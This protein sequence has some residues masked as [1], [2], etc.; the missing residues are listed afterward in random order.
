MALKTFWRTGS[1]GSL[2][3]VF[4][5]CTLALADPK[6]A[7]EPMGP[8]GDSLGSSISPN[9]EHIAVLANQGSHLAVFYDGVA[10]PKIEALQMGTASNVPY[11][12]PTYYS[13]QVPI[14]FSDDGAHWAYM[15]R[16]G[17][18][19]I[20]MLDGK[21]L[22]RAPLRSNEAD[23]IPLTFSSKGR[24]L[25]Y[26]DVDATGAYQVVVDGK[27]GPATHLLPSIA[28]SPDGQHYAYVGA[29][30]NSGVGVWS[31]VDG[32]QVNYF[33]DHLQ[34][35]GR[36][37][38]V[39]LLP[40]PGGIGLV[41]DGKPEI[42][43]NRLD[44][45]WM[46]PD[47]ALIAIV[48]TPNP[49]T[50]SVLTINGKTIDGTQ[51]LIIE[52]VYFSPDGKRWA[53]LCDKKTGSKFMMVDGQKG[54]DYSNIM[55]S[56]PPVDNV[57]H[58]RYQMDD[59]NGNDFSPF[60]LPVPGFTADS[61]K[62]VYAALA[63]GRVFMIVDGTESSGFQNNTGFSPV[64]STVGNHI[65]AVGTAPNN[66]QHLIID[67]AEVSSIPSATMGTGTALRQLT[68]S[69]GAKH[70]AF[71]Q[72]QTL[73]L[74]SVAQPGFLQNN[75]LF[76]PDD[77]HLAYEAS[78][79][80]RPTLVV[81]GKVISDKPG[82]VSRIFFSPDSQHVCWYSTG[83]WAALGTK[84]DMQLYVDGKPATHFRLPL[85]GI[86]LRCSFGPDDT[87]TFM[88]L[89]DG[90]IRRFHVTPDT[91]LAAVLASAPVAKAN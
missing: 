47:G 27:A 82:M 11:Q 78:V 85:N 67:G 17:D 25:F 22:V 84:D 54:D 59:P 87:M 56:L 80:G 90:S 18:D 70:Y 89:T 51:G 43:A 9:G 39:S 37:H 29:Y 33:G 71:V 36:D 23:R 41:L 6:T 52:K 64:L 75:Y 81:D 24:H 49:Q 88:A 13:G 20:V 32:R 53:A 38:L 72:S 45:M 69:P 50:P 55:I 1:A 68:F 77:S 76:S 44:P 63:G 74:D 62:F 60:Q 10:G 8:D 35:S 26:S 48:V 61:S 7:Q 31:F 15:A 21:E 66:K 5:Q 57:M 14:I 30:T 16:S 79:S 28:F 86:P 40:I 73:F 19:F 58:W 3:L 42:K 12:T 4:L 46:S 2:G 34:Y 83:N 91:S 65:G